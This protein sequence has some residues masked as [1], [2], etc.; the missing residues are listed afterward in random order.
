MLFIDLSKIYDSVPGCVQCKVLKQY[1]V[2]KVMIGLLRSLHDG[3]EVEVTTHGC[4]S[5]TINMTNGLRQ[6]CTI[7]STLFALYLNFVIECW[8]DIVRIAV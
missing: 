8:C 5:P 1:G 2:P 6:G 4:I 7:A 3:M